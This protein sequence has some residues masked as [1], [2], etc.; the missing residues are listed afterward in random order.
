MSPDR[1]MLAIA[2][3]EGRASPDLLTLEEVQEIMEKTIDSA[4]NYSKNSNRN[5]KLH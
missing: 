1:E 5:N 4:A 3:L 2:V